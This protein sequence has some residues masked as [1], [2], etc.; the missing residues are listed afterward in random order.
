VTFYSACISCA[1][2]R[3]DGSETVTGD[4]SVF[5][6]GMNSGLHGDI[7]RRALAAALFGRAGRVGSRLSRGSS[8]RAYRSPSVKT[9]E[10][11]SRDRLKNSDFS[12]ARTPVL[13]VLGDRTGDR[14][15][16]C[17][18]RAT[19]SVRLCVVLQRQRTR[20]LRGAAHRSSPL[21]AGQ[22]DSCGPSLGRQK[23]CSASA[24]AILTQR[25][26]IRRCGGG[27]GAGGGGGVL[28]VFWSRRICLLHQR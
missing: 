7:P 23:T 20:C 22:S 16:V 9:R 15:F 2:S 1:S 26:R 27:G 19:D 3:D 21:L 24:V 25:G 5:V 12:D 13:G 28:S 4:D 14:P 6:Q 10:R 11:L 18:A 17:L 8:T